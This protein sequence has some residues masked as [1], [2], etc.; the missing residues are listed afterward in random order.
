MLKEEINTEYADYKF[1]KWYYCTSMYLMPVFVVLLVG[2]W[3][4]QSIGWY[5]ETWW[6]PFEKENLGTIIFQFAI[7]LAISFGLN[8]TLAKKIAKGPMSK[9][10]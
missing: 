9:K 8:N 1:P 3:G 6:S 10:D 2:W 7:L 4:I 5:P